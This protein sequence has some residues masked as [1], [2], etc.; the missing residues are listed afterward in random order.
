MTGRSFG[1]R[2]CTKKK[3]A[4]LTNPQCSYSILSHSWNPYHRKIHQGEGL[5]HCESLQ[6]AFRTVP[7]Q[8][9]RLCAEAL[10]LQS[11]VPFPSCEISETIIV[12]RYIPE[13]LKICK[14]LALCVP[15]DF[16]TQKVSL[17]LPMHFD[18][19]NVE[20]CFLPLFFPRGNFNQHDF[21]WRVSCKVIS[22]KLQDEKCK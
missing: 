10:E 6:T 7:K 15:I 4:S 12:P 18:I 22:F 16:Y 9:R 5:H 13:Y 2:S 19:V 20:Q 21:C 8:T 11:V 17:A 3:S 1:Q 14:L